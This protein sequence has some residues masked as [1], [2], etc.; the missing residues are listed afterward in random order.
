MIEAGY[1]PVVIDNLY[2]TRIEVKSAIEEITG[3]EIEF[4]GLDAKNTDEVVDLPKYV[5]FP[6]NWTGN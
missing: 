4:Y 5:D 6:K 3:R 1:Q 2:N